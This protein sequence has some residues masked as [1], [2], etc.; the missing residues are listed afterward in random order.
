[1]VELLVQCAYSTRVFFIII[2]LLLVSPCFPKG[3]LH[4]TFLPLIF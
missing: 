3:E 2:V 1:M 4:Y